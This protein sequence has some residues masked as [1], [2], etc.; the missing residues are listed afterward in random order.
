MKFI[1]KINEA[2]KLPTKLNTRVS[3]E[4]IR[5][6]SRGY[7]EYL[8]EKVRNIIYEE[9]KNADNVITT[10]DLKH[11][12]LHYSDP[13]DFS[14]GISIKDDKSCMGKFIVYLCI[15]NDSIIATQGTTYHMYLKLNTFL[16]DIC[17]RHSDE[18]SDIKLINIS[19]K[20]VDYNTQLNPG[21]SANDMQAMSFPESANKTWNIFELPLSSNITD[22]QWNSIIEYTQR[23]DDVVESV[24]LM[25]NPNE[26]LPISDYITTLKKVINDV[27]P[28]FKFKFN[29]L[30][31]ENYRIVRDIALKSTL[32]LKKNEFLDIFNQQ[33]MSKIAYDFDKFYVTLDHETA[34]ICITNNAELYT[35]AEKRIQLCSTK[36]SQI[37]QLV[38]SIH[39]QYD[40][41]DAEYIK[42][43]VEYVKMIAN[44]L[45]TDLQLN[46]PIYDSRDISNVHT[47]CTDAGVKC[48]HIYVTNI[49]T[50]IKNTDIYTWMHCIQQITDIATDKTDFYISLPISTVENYVE[51]LMNKYPDPNAYQHM[52][53]LRA[54]YGILRALRN[55]NSLDET[56]RLFSRLLYFPEK[57][58]FYAVVKNVHIDL[59]DISK[60]ILQKYNSL[61]DEYKELKW[62]QYIYNWVREALTKLGVIK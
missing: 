35:P 25:L 11:C 59:Y 6:A 54:F 5:I 37:N 40:F 19:T 38:L 13:L 50:Y 17:N 7:I 33:S 34:Y 51:N 8:R 57:S 52:N 10:D 55:M 21:T 23:F 28:K 12:C 53:I 41:L 60:D 49:S 1:R 56:E 42:F 2:V 29:L 22:D 36:I 48:S 3:L 18:I 9:F 15:A 16:N 26:D 14:P 31:V 44:P 4:D 43:W 62:K 39:D 20:S 27:L 58:K 24:D 47:A 32:N 61:N 30:L 46:V 45:S